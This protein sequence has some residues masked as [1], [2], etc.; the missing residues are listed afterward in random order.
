MQPLFWF[1]SLLQARMT[2]KLGLRYFWSTGTGTGTL[3][4]LFVHTSYRQKFRRT[5]I[6]VVF[7]TTIRA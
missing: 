5:G 3:V 1:L 7:L 2:A 4:C 6:V